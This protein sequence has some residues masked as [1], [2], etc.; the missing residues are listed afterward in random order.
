MD[1]LAEHKAVALFH[2][3]VAPYLHRSPRVRDNGK[4][5]WAAQ[6]TLWFCNPA[7]IDDIATEYPEVTIIIAHFGVQGFYY[8][9][10]YADMALLVAARHDN[11]YLET[12]V[13]AEV[14]GTPVMRRQSR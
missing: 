3:G 14:D 9:G 11:V 2:T 12:I 8:F 7:F 4:Q 13:T 6:R 1:V 5:G 10:A